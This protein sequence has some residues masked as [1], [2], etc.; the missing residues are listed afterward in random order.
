MFIAFMFSNYFDQANCTT[1]SSKVTMRSK[2]HLKLRKWENTPR[3]GAELKMLVTN[4]RWVYFIQEN[5][6]YTSPEPLKYNGM[7]NWTMTYKRSSDVWAPYGTY[8]TVEDNDLRRSYFSS[9][10]GYFLFVF[11]LVAGVAKILESLSKEVL[12]TM[13]RTSIVSGLFSLLSSGFA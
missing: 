3:A 13:P 1:L 5:P 4:Q 11:L 10:A 12:F 8:R 7:F 2:R 6:H 9:G